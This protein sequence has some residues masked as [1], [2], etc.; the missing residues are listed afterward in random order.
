MTQSNPFGS[1]FAVFPDA[2]SQAK[3]C[4]RATKPTHN[5]TTTDRQTTT[6]KEGRTHNSG[7]A[8][9]AAQCSADTFV[10]NQSLVL[11]IN[12]SGKNRHLRQAANRYLLC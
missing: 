11:R 4:K 3:N 6:E 5:D 10:V 8:K 7:L 1:T 2:Q 9:V 12:I